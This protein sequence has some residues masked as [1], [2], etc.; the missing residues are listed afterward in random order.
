MVGIKAPIDCW[1]IA[2]D[3]VRYVGEPVA[4]VVASDRYRAEAMLD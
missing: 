4:V 2:T 1:P 3:R